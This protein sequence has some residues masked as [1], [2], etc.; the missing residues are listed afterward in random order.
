[1]GFLSLYLSFIF[2]SIHEDLICVLD[3]PITNQDVKRKLDTPMG[4]HTTYSVSL[5]KA[6]TIVGVVSAC[7]LMGVYYILGS[8]DWYYVV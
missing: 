5:L 7:V 4:W 3:F 6:I 1:M 8:H 2:A